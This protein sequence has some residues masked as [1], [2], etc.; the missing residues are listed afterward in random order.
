MPARFSAFGREFSPSWLMTLA[1]LVLLGVFVS[2]GRWQWARGETKQAVWAEFQR[3]AAAEP[4]GTRRFDEL[5]RFASIEVEGVFDG[6]RQ[7]L[8]DNRSHQGKPGYEV[9][10]PFRTTGGALLLV[11]RGWVPFSGYRDQLP[12]VSALPSSSNERMK[13]SGRVEELPAAGLA[14]G[15]LPPESGA[16]WPKLTSFP[17]HEQLAAALGEKIEARILL[18]DPQLPGGYVRDWKPP[19]LDPSRHFSYA[20][21]WWGFAVVLLVLYFGLNFRK[22]T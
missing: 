5:P 4:L 8:L 21:Q 7:F 12:D 18:L 9:L 16:R 2:L 13:I 17:T 20:I 11:N 15:R 3:Q 10:T 14:S 19:G 22:V 1:T 6:G